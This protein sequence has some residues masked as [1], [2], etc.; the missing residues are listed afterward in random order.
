M[1]SD[2]DI[3][4]RYETLNLGIENALIRMNQRK[5]YL[6]NEIVLESFE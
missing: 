4:K 6:L 3:E 1:L 2:L 5:D